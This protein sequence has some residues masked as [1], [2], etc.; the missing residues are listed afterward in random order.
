LGLSA[1]YFLYFRFSVFPF[2]SLNAVITRFVII[3]VAGMVLGVLWAYVAP[4]KKPKGPAPA[5]T[6]D[7]PPAAAMDDE[8]PAAAIDDEPPAAAIDDEPPAAAID[9]E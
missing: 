6:E 8:P 7:E 3:I 1:A 9:D 2:D 5:M 4:A